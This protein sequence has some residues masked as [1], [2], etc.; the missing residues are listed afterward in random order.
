MSAVS[1][2]LLIWRLMAPDREMMDRRFFPSASVSSLSSDHTRLKCTPLKNNAHGGLNMSGLWNNAAMESL[3]CQ[4]EE[5]NNDGE[6][7]EI[8]S[9]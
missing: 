1:P 6:F 9:G 5:S 8:L 3:I 7:N 2:A 4:C